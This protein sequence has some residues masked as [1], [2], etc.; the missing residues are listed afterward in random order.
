MNG[1]KTW[2][3]GRLVGIARHSAQDKMNTLETLGEDCDKN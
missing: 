1:H 3:L 2:N